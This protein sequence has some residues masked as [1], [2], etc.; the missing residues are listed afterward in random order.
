VDSYVSIFPLHRF[1]KPQ[2]LET[3]L[4]IHLKYVTLYF[5]QK[6]I[7]CL[8][9]LQDTAG[10]ALHVIITTMSTTA[11]V[12]GPLFIGYAVSGVKK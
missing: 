11:L 3:Q 2:L 7:V 9:E 4:V 5:S 12:L 10:P 8:L 6:M 1:T